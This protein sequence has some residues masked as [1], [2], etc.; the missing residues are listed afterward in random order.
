MLRCLNWIVKDCYFLF[1]ALSVLR[2][3]FKFFKKITKTNKKY[4]ILNL[5]TNRI[6]VKRSTK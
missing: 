6:S 4:E 5:K 1:Q 2:F 3:K